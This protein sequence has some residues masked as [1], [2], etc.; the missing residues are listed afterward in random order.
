MGDLKS[1]LLKAGFKAS[2]SG[3]TKDKKREPWLKAKRVSFI[4]NKEIIVKYVKQSSLM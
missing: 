3:E 1:A 2:K 4:R